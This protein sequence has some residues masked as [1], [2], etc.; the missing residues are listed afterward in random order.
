MA[1]G[2]G[3]KAVVVAEAHVQRAVAH[4]LGQRTEDVAVEQRAGGAEVRVVAGR[5]RELRALAGERVRDGPLVLVAGA[6]VGQHREAHR[7]GQRLRRGDEAAA[8]AADAVDARRPRVAGVG[9][10]A[11]EQPRRRPHLGARGVERHD[12][13]VAAAAHPPAQLR[14]AR[15][16]ARQVGAAPERPVAG[17]EQVRHPVPDRCE[18]RDRGQRDQHPERAD[19]QPRA[20]Q[21]ALEQGG[22]A[23]GGLGTV[24]RRRGLVRRRV[25]AGGTFRVGH[26]HEA[27]APV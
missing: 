25:A 4:Q 15:R 20:P 17:P 22:A 16:H 27:T 21:L 18:D 24:L 11:G 9:A 26:G 1:P 19:Q 23:L 10:E 12:L 3:R 2:P 13:D 14:L 6:V 8:G 7:P 5:D